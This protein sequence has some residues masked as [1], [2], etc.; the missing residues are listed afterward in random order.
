MAARLEAAKELYRAN[1]PPSAL[2]HRTFMK[3]LRPPAT[4][5]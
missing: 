5:S 4:E 3:D 1:R 2:L